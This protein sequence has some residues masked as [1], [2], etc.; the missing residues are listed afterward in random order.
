MVEYLAG[1]RIRGTLTEMEA[2]TIANISDGSVFYATDTNKEYVL[3]SS[4][5]LWRGLNDDYVTYQPITATGGTVYTVGDYKTHKFT[6]SGNLVITDVPSGAT[7]E[8]LVIAGGGGGGGL[9]GA[10][11]GA[12]GLIYHGTYTPTTGTKSV[13]IGAGGSGGANNGYGSNGN[14]STFDGFTGF[15]GGGGSWSSGGSNARVGN[16]GGCCGGNVVSATTGTSTQTS[17]NG[18][19]GYGNVQ[20]KTGIHE[21]TFKVVMFKL[22]VV[23]VQV[24]M[25]VELEQKLAEVVLLGEAV[26]LV[27]MVEVVQVLMLILF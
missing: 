1:N 8:V 15:A 9:H 2:L 27:E 7:C 6:S 23:V 26:E 10:G 20:A 21:G 19:T 13:T 11:G 18:G 5:S 4:D 24:N 17:H 25:V 12:G 22:H 16:N 14:N 3:D